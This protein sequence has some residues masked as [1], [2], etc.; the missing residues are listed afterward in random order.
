MGRREALMLRRSVREFSH[1]VVD[2]DALRDSIAE[3]SP[4]PHRITPAG[5]VRVAAQP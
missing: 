3:R 1:D 2:P 4:H 5:A